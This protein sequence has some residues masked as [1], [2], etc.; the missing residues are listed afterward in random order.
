MIATI[1]SSLFVDIHM[2]TFAPTSARKATNVTIDAALLEHAKILRINISQA[3][4]DGLARAVAAKRAD[5]W[6]QDNQAA[7]ESSNAYVD[8]NGVPLAKHRNF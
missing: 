5:I 8:R 4:E 7:L 3:S 2:K 1:F 6:L